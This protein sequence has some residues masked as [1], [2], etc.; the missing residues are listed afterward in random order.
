MIKGDINLLYPFFMSHGRIVVG[1]VC[2]LGCDNKMFE[3]LN[4]IIFLT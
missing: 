1:A 3:G 4:S 2:L